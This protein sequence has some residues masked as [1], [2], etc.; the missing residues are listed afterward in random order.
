MSRDTYLLPNGRVLRYSFHER[1]AHW[2][3]GVSYVY[4]LLTGLAFWSPWLFGSLS[5]SVAQRFHAS[6][7]LGWASS[8]S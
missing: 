1:L 8:S 2:L 7:I 3:A 5:S 4:L 6:C